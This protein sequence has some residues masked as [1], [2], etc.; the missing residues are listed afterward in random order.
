MGNR[1]LAF[2]YKKKKKKLMYFC[3]V[4]SVFGILIHEFLSPSM[5]SIIT[6]ESVGHNKTE[7]RI[8]RLIFELNSN[9]T[10]P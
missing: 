6:F 10:W 7:R 8:E 5:F 3:V 4:L 1:V 9:E 2:S